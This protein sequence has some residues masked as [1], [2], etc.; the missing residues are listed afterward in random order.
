MWLRKVKP[1][2]ILDFFNAFLTGD[3]VQ[4][5]EAALTIKKPDFEITNFSMYADIISKRIDNLALN[6]SD[7]SPLAIQELQDMCVSVFQCVL[8][9]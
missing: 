7:N 1:D 4:D 8:Y 9:Y 2:W 6:S 5:F 3:Y